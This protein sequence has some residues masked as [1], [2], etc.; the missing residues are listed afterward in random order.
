VDTDA[1]LRGLSLDETALEFNT[2]VKSHITLSDG[3][4]E[5]DFD[6]HYEPEHLH[7]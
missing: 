6:T 1:D 5:G 2:Q 3:Q 7:F 4:R